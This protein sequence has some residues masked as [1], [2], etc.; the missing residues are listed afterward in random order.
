LTAEPESGHAVHALAHVH[1][2][3]NDHAV[4]LNWLDR[5]VT[6]S[7]PG[8]HHRAHF[9][10][11]AALHELAIGDDSALRRRYETQ[12][13]PP[14]VAGIRSLVDSASL[15]WR[16]GLEGA[17]EGDLPIVSV[18]EAAGDEVL[19]RPATP[20]AAMHS[21]VALSA[22]GDVAALVRLERFAREHARPVFSGVVAPVV[23]GFRRYVE[24]DYA[25]SAEML[26]WVEPCLVEL[27]GSA[28]QRE[29]VQ[30]TLLHGLL[31]AGRFEQARDVLERRLDRRPSRR[32][33]CRLSRL[34]SLAQ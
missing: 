22:A 25:G 21:A 16:A 13:A 15:L 19:A 26:L 6:E 24:G 23:E 11:H 31:A 27:G 2:E 9:S 14:A 17:W 7:G 33:L 30:D 29:V 4:G 10:W 1:Y 5:W 32:D 18:L 28:A 12:L 34:E 3:T 8:A 20:F